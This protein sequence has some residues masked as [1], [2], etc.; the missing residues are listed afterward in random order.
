MGTP[1]SPWQSS[2]NFYIPL[3]SVDCKKLLGEEE[4][5]ADVMITGKLQPLILR[6]QSPFLSLRISGDLGRSRFSRLLVLGKVSHIFVRPTRI[7][8]VLIHC[9]AA[10]SSV[11][12]VHSTS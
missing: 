2:A 1:E 9:H 4:A 11:K 7:N 3:L 5:M 12:M 6:R 10:Y 8:R